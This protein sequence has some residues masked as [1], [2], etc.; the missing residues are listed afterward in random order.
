MLCPFR[1]DTRTEVSRREDGTVVKKRTE[2]WA[3]C[4]YNMCP[5]C[6]EL[7]CGDK[8]TY[9]CSRCRE[10]KFDDTTLHSTASNSV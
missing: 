5:Y 8:H 3:Q 4:N 7:Q 1:I 2:N 9:S 6:V 10:G